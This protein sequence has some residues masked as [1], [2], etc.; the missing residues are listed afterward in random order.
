MSA[1]TEKL[2]QTLRELHAELE[3][4]GSVDPEMRALLE[5]TVAEIQSALDD[6]GRGGGVRRTADDTSVGDRLAETARHFEV[7][8]PTLSAA[9]GR[10]IDALAALGI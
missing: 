7:S 8:H 2:R 10:V 6:D 4:Q 3:T 5:S 9:L 1:R